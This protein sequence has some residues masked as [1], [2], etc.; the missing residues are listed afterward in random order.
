MSTTT[1]PDLW[2]VLTDRD[3]GPAIRLEHTFRTTPD[4]LW[5]AVTDPERLGRWMAPTV[6]D[7]PA[8]VGCRYV[9]DF[10][11][12]GTSSGAVT[13]C[14]APRRYEVTWE[15]VG[16]PDSVVLVEV[17]EGPDGAVLRIDHTRLPADQAHGHAAGWQAHLTGL[18]ALLEGGPAPA[19]DE[20]FGGLLPAY[21]AT[22][23]DLAGR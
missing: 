14:E 10:G 21:R 1:T 16:E 18:G 20:L 8:G 7:G 9:I 15:L 6:L 12:D 5:E 11:A 3:S 23:P 22:Y 2:G 17:D 13:R 19:W 4:D